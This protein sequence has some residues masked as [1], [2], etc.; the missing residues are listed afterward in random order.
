MTE[1]I[2][3]TGI[4]KATI[5]NVFLGVILVFSKEK[6]KVYELRQRTSM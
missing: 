6:T 4:S 5:A 2:A 1:L 3:V